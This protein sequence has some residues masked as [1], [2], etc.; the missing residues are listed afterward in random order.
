M[1]CKKKSI[2]SHTVNFKQ[3][4]STA[5]FAVKFRKMF[6]ERKLTNVL[7]QYFQNINII[8]KSINVPLCSMQEEADS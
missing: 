7:Y 1:F 4:I 8:K 6:P 2:V 5:I 3:Q